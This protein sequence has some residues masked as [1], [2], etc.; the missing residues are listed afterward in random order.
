MANIDTL[1][2]SKIDVKLEPSHEG[3]VIVHC[4]YQTGGEESLIR[5]W[6]TTFLKAIGDPHQSELIHAEGITLYPT[7]LVLPPNSKHRFTLIFSALPKHIT[8]FDLVEDIPQAG[9][10]EVRNIQRNKTDVYR[11]QM[12]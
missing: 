7:W 11:V 12:K 9:G 4:H 3:Q 5:I 10:F 2:K 8:L 1:K 6:Q